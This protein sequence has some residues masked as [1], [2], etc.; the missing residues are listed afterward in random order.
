LNDPRLPFDQAR[1]ERF[2]K[3]NFTAAKMQG[4]NEIIGLVPAGGRATRIA[5]LPCSKEL[6]PI[7]FHSAG[8]GLS[9]RPK[10]VAQYLLEKMRIA[11]VAKGYIV[12]RPGKWDIPAYFGDGLLLQMH[13]AY[14]MMR[15]PLGVPYTLDQAYP[16]VKDAIVAMGF[17]DILFGPDDAFVQLLSR[18]YTTDPDALLGMFPTDLP[19][20]ED[21]VDVDEKGRVREIVIK[22]HHTKL[23]YTWGIALWTPVFTKFLHEYLSSRQDPSPASRE[24]TAGDVIQ[25]AIEN[26]L[27]VDAMPVSKDPYLDIGTPERLLK[28][29]KDFA[30]H[31]DD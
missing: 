4:S 20:H 30:V 9:S 27:R 7:G 5:P 16:F 6:Y 19:E 31:K 14:L 26:H 29:V 25:A 21:L 18:R 8:G 22:P 24:L 23:R 13:L 10:V 15:S 11:G 28:A 12:L 1:G 3:P 2:Y 17:P